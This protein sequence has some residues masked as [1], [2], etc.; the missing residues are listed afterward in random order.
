VFI[1]ECF[2]SVYNPRQMITRRGFLSGA[3]ALTATAATF[4]MVG[5]SAESAAA[6]IGQ[7]P[8]RII[9]MVSDGMS[10]GT[11]TAADHFAQMLRGRGL[12]WM[13][14]YNHPG[15]HSGLMNMRSLNSLVTDSSAAASSWGSGARII[16]GVVNQAGD[17]TELKTLYQLF[18][19]AGWRTG[20][21]TTTE[22][23]HATPSG[24][25]ASVESR[26]KATTIAGQ[27][28]KREI[29]VL[30][31]GGSKFF[32]K[33][34]RVDK[35]DLRGEFQKAGYYVMDSLSQLSV[36]PTNK[37]WLGT[38]ARSH[39]PFTLDQLSDAK[40]RSEVPTL[41]AM[42]AA[43]L[44]RLEGESYFILQ[45]EGGRVD[46]ACHNND[47]SAALHDQIAFDEAIDVCLEYQKRDPETLIVITTDHGNSN[48]GMNG[49][50]DAYGQSTWMLRSMKDVKSSF[51]KMLRPLKRQPAVEQPDKEADAEADKAREKAKSHEQKEREKADKKKVEENVATPTEIIEIIAEHTGYKLPYRKAE[52]LRLCLS[53]TGETLYDMRKSDVCAL[54]DV[55]ANH[56]GI[57]FSGN[58]HTGDYVPV[59]AIGPGAERFRGFIQNTEVF[60]H[61][62]DLAGIDFR[63]PQEPLINAQAPHAGQVE[64]VRP[65][66]FA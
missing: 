62:T 55:M 23:T 31:G 63:N 19:Q 14:L 49:S 30:L 53:N 2:L 56:L 41:A 52:L 21:V 65:Y 54:G 4:P 45:V 17:G 46:H 20:L 47:A 6:K 39:L 1:A 59:L 32:D 57:G 15:A 3:S 22:I 11:L 24:F 16:N 61:Y 18:G 5:R 28:L 37:R 34:Y 7:K 8:K 35:R 42:T 13:A 36:A 10:A 38:F 40:A 12:S 58:A 50:G 60:D 9:H 29:D 48:L 66:R 43:A 27:Y 25:A 51:S 33:D 44:R 64:D 26:D